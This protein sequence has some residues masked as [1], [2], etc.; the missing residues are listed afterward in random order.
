MFPKLLGNKQQ[1]KRS[2]EVHI[3][4]HLTRVWRGCLDP[5]VQLSTRRGVRPQSECYETAQSLRHT[6]AHTIPSADL[7]SLLVTIFLR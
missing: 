3:K 1:M 4:K 2:T 5:A 6:Y 7:T